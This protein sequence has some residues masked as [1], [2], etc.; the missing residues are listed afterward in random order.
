MYEYINIYSCVPHNYH[1]LYTCTVAMF[2]SKVLLALQYA[3]CL[4]F[5]P[6]SFSSILHPHFDL[7]MVKRPAG[8]VVLFGTIIITF[9]LGLEFLDRLTK[10]DYHVL[11]VHWLV[12]TNQNQSLQLLFRRWQALHAN[13]SRLQGAAVQRMKQWI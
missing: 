12:S 10:R 9:W 5:Y 8:F 3:V 6:W 13:H 11:G 1:V 4:S 2:V 7:L